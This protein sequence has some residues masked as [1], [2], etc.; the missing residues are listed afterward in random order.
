VPWAGRCRVANEHH[1]ATA[2][3]F[4]VR[5][6]AV[7]VRANS[8]AL[9]ASALQ[10]IPGKGALCTDLTQQEMRC[11]L[12]TAAHQAKTRRAAESTYFATFG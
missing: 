3:C 12:S 10:W 4:R 2:V 7:L 6:A 9:L 1:A 8:S 11:I 5:G